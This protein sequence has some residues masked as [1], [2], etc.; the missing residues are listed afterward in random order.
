MLRTQTQTQTQLTLTQKKGFWVIFTYIRNPTDLLEPIHE[1]NLI[2][3]HGFPRCTY[4]VVW[5]RQQWNHLCCTSTSTC[6]CTCISY[7]YRALRSSEQV[8]ALLEALSDSSEA[9]RGGIGM[10]TKDIF[11]IRETSVLVGG[12][13]A[14][15]EDVGQGERRRLLDA[16]QQ[17][18]FVGWR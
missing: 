11:A 9:V 8:T 7:R 13:V 10:K 12:D 15:G 14:S 2:V 5:E 1:A 18:D 16:M 4:H 3:M 6:A 17:E